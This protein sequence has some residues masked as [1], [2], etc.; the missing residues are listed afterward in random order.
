MLQAGDEIG[1]TQRGNN[2][3]YCQDNELTWL[4]WEPD[5]RKSALLKFVRRVA[6]VFHEQPVF[7]R[8]RFFHGKAI[9]G[10]EAP[11]ISWL[12][13]SGQEMNE[14]AW[15]DSFVRCLGV[16]LFGGEIDVDDHGEPIFGDTMLLMFNA[17]HANT[18]PFTFPKPENGDPWELVFDTARPEL[19][20]G[21]LRAAGGQKIQHAALFRC[22]LSFQGAARGG[23]II[24][25]PPLFPG[26]SQRAAPHH[27]Q[28]LIRGVAIN[29]GRLRQPSAG[30]RQRPA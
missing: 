12:D 23:S 13:P 14:Q 2:N 1:R 27:R 4:H 21:R 26:R 8:R 29:K 28:A 24:S 15:K 11:E 19:N 25:R 16:Q 10:A 7:H 5:E 18:I 3:A 9:Q 30:R 20:R 6:R 17:D 22:R